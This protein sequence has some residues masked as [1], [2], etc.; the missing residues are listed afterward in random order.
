MPPIPELEEIRRKQIIDATLLTLSHKGY[1]K[2]TMAEIAA[3]ANMSKGGLAHYFQSKQELFKAAFTEFY[4][5]I[6]DRVE[7]EADLIDDPLDKLLGFESL[8]AADDP[9]VEWGYPLLFDCMS[10]AGRDPEYRTLFSRW[11]DNWV[12][13][14]SRIIR[15]GMDAGLFSP[16]EPE[17]MART[18]SAIY[19]GV[20]TRW[21]LAPEDHSYEWAF[22]S[23]QTAIRGLMAPY[24]IANQP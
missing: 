5:L 9:D 8:F 10:V 7:R 3:A 20:A 19:Q 16:L 11:V 12:V 2:A 14:L 15:E 6:F 23:Y 22:H 1:A 4:R 13:L 17:P 18:I 21:F 24:I